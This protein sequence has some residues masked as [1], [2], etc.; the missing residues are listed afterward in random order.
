MFPLLLSI[1]AECLN[2]LTSVSCLLYHVDFD[3]FKEC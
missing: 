2:A 3:G 1:F